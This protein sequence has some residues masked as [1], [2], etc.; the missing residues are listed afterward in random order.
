MARSTDTGTALPEFWDFAKDFKSVSGWVA[1]A[2]VAAPLADIVL[3]IGPPWPSRPSVAILLCIVEVVVLMY[4]F[5]FWRHGSPRIQHIRSVMR[6]AIA[7]VAVAFVVYMPLFAFFIVDAEDAWHRVVIGYKMHDDVAEMQKSD[8]GQWTP[9]ELILQFH[10]VMAVWTPWSVN[11]MRTIVLLVWL[12]VWAALSVVIS[13][14]V[15]IQWR[16]L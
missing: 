16:R 9:E 12:L 13:A 7:A 1:K 14:F 3:N 15:A 6:A 11:V 2:A 5:E 10:D 8:P 4:S